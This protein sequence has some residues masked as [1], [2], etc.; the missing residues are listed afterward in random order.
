MRNITLYDPRLGL[1]VT[2][3]LILQRDPLDFLE[4]FLGFDPFRTTTLRQPAIDVRENDKAYLIEAELP[5]LTEKD[6]KIE[7]KDSVL[8]LKVEKEEKAEAKE[9]DAAKAEDEKWI[10]RERRDYAFARS[11]SLP[12]NADEEAIEARFKDGILMIALPKK[13]ERAP[14]QVSIKVA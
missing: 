1:R 3:D 2:N 13:P 12:E 11:F 7:V 6:V 9:G 14:R 10:R 5:G 4:D 8:T